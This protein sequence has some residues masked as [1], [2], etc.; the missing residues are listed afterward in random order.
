MSGGEEYDFPLRLRP[1]DS[2]NLH[3]LIGKEL[4]FLAVSDDGSIQAQKVVKITEEHV[5]IPEEE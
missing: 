2:L 4:T 5:Q 1:K 3:A